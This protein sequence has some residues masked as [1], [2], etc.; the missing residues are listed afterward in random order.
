MNW[1]P[2]NPGWLASAMAVWLALWALNT[3]LA[4]HRSR[5]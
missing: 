1:A 3:V 2:A 5:V 4:G